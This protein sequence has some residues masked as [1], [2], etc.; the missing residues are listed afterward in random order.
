MLALALNRCPIFRRNGRFGTSSR[1]A[2]LIM[3]S[4]AIMEQPCLAVIGSA[5]GT[6][7]PSLTVPY[8]ELQ[9]KVLHMF[10]LNYTRSNQGQIKV[11]RKGRE[12]QSKMKSGCFPATPVSLT[13]LFGIQLDVSSNKT[14]ILITRAPSLSEITACSGQKIRRIRR[15]G[16]AEELAA[17]EYKSPEIG[18]KKG[19]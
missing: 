16:E 8:G 6:G 10:L 19:K 13:K 5:I 1:L 17:S 15:A 4:N 18:L 12:E 14:A 7:F 3:A 11:L 2:N 9:S